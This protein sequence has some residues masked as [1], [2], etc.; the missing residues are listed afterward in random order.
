[1]LRGFSPMLIFL[2]Q[3]EIVV[4]TIT[5]KQYKQQNLLNSLNLITNTK[6]PTNPDKWHSLYA[7]FKGPTTKD[8]GTTGQ[9]E[10]SSW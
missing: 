1:M 8:R 2:N 10:C 3:P 5:R 7:M 9:V 4:M 6:Q